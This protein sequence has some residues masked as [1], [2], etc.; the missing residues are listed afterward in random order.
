MIKFSQL[1]LSAMLLVAPLTASADFAFG[2]PGFE[3]NSAVLDDRGKEILTDAATWLERLPN[4]KLRIYGSRGVLE[5][6]SS[7]SMERLR[8]AKRFL[9]GIGIKE[10][11][12]V[13]EDVGVS[14][15]VRPY[16]KT[17]EF[18]DECDAF[19]RIIQ[20]DLFAP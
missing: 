1:T 10:D 7:I 4:R 14:R 20:L 19:N 5:K 15:P 16:C 13:L 8:N 12:I 18:P 6:D 11:R 9:L 3:K 17:E 2:T